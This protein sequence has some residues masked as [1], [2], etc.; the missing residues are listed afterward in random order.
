MRISADALGVVA[1]LARELGQVAHDDTGVT[2]EGAGGRSGLERLGGAIEKRRLE[3]LLEVGDAL[4]DRRGGDVLH[5]GSAGDALLFT[6]RDEQLQR[7]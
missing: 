2:E 4:A 6:D 1:K 7:Q 5:L 3:H